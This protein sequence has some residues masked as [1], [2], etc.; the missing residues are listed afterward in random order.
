MGCGIDRHDGQP[1]TACV[2]RLAEQG[3][4]PNPKMNGPKP[5]GNETV[6]L[7]SIQELRDKWQPLPKRAAF[8]PSGLGLPKAVVQD[9]FY[10]KLKRTT[11]GVPHLIAR[12]RD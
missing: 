4:I 11:E 6:L 12:P 7:L 2:T 8:P 5:R 9:W 10:R 1:I 3:E